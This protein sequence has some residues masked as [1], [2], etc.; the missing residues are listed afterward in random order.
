V[1]KEDMIFGKPMKVG[2]IE[3]KKICHCRFGRLS[4]E[5]PNR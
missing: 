4:A 5:V 2:Q 3:V 1:Q